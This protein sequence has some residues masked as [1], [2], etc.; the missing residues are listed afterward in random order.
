VHLLDPFTGGMVTV[1]AVREGAVATSGLG[2][3]LW[4]SGEGP[5]HHLLDPA[6]G[7]PAWTGVVSAT[8][9]APA[10]TSWTGI[11][12]VAGYLGALL[13]LSFFVRKRVGAKRWRN[14][15]RLTPL[16][17]VLAVT[18]TLGAGIDASAAWLRAGLV[19]LSAPLVHLA[20]LRVLPARPSSD[21]GRAAPVASGQPSA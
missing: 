4:W 15:H 21:P 3:R 12:I 13:G 11:G 18:H 2:S 17:Y 1:L 6:T 5:V 7:T 14:A 20:V 8:A 19:G 9:L 10:R 16:V